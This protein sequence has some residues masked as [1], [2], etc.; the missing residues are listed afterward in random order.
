[1]EWSTLP[2]PSTWVKLPKEL[3]GKKVNVLDDFR[4]SSCK[5]GKHSARIL[6]LDRNYVCVEC[7]K[8]KGFYWL[9]TPKDI[10][11][12]KLNIGASTSD[13]KLINGIAC[14]YDP[15]LTSMVLRKVQNP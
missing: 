3:G 5:C 10:N 14:Y 1:M 8:T 11:Q 2:I 4:S 12:F 15:D 6:I 7:S 9:K 13:Y